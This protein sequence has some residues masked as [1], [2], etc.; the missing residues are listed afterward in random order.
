M[1]GGRGQARSDTRSWSPFL[2]KLDGPGTKAGQFGTGT[3]S[4]TMKARQ[5]ADNQKQQ[6]PQTLRP[7]CPKTGTRKQNSSKTSG[8]LSRVGPAFDQLL[9]KHMKKAI[10]HDRPL[11]RIGSKRRSRQKQRRTKLAQ[12]LVHARSPGHPL[13]GMS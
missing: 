1:E 10:P 2:R 5:S 6:W 12:K 8:R 7:Q 13:S 11:K 3:E 9:A 4:P